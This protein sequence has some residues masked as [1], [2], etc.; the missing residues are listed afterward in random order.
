MADLDTRIQRVL[1]ELE[2]PYLTEQKEATLKRRL[3][4]LQEFKEQ[5]RVS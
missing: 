4:T 5:E 1:D 3:K 2:D